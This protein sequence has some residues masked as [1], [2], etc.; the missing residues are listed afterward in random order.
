[1]SQQTE[2]E[3][4]QR[5]D[6][7]NDCPTATFNGRHDAAGTAGRHQK[8]IDAAELPRST[9]L[10]LLRDAARLIRQP[11]L[12]LATAAY[13]AVSL[14]LLGAALWFTSPPTV[15]FLVVLGWLLFPL[16]EYVVHR[17]VLHPLIYLDNRISARFWI[18][19]HY[20]HHDHPSRTDVIL[21]SP[22]SVLMLVVVLNIPIALIAGP[23]AIFAGALAI[24]GPFMFYEFVHFAA[25][26]PI[27][28][29]S[30]YL[31]N[32]KRLH[33]L[34]HFHNEERNF[35]ICSSIVDRLVGTH[36]QEFRDAERSATAKNLGYDETLACEKPLV[37][38][39]Y[40]R[41]YLGQ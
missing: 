11:E 40:V 19:V 28:C 34:H 3:V 21:A 33:L 25:H 15:A 39:E 18:R 4:R 37:R 7:A 22:V 26:A 16:T 17:Y 5:I 41:R 14:C 6:V 10:A 27:D 30:P 2:P 32:R 35:G 23:G 1:M 31:V 9:P 29:A 24:I 36:A 12:R 8:H 20:A 38:I 13:I